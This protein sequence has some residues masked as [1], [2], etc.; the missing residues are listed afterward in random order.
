[1]YDTQLAFNQMYLMVCSEVVHL[2]PEHLSPEVFTDKLH[3]VQLVLKAGRVPGQPR[4]SKY[5]MRH[6]L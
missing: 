5:K 2:P 1:M 4:K 3:Y 6:L